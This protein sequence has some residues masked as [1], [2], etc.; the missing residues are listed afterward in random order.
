M[1]L[2]ALLKIQFDDIKAKKDYAHHKNKYILDRAATGTGKI[3]FGNVN[4]ANFWA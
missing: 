3:I 4:F 1:S 2:K